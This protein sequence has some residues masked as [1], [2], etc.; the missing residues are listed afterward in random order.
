MLLPQFK[1]FADIFVL[2]FALASNE[3]EI[4]FSVGSR[5]DMSS[6]PF[7]AQLLNGLGYIALNR[8][9][10]QSQMDHFVACAVISQI[11]NNDQLLILFQ[12]GERMRNGRLTQPTEA[13]LSIDWLLQAYH[14][15]FEWTNKTLHLV[16]VSINY[17]RLF[18]MENLA[19]EIMNFDGKKPGMLSVEEMRGPK[20]QKAV[21]KA[22][23][24]FGESIE[25]T[26]YLQKKKGTADFSNELLHVEALPLSYDLVL[27]K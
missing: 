21:G 7:L 24:T 19:T 18:D 15:S 17:D 4:P 12:N 1:S 8:S 3:I 14:S 10:D 22:Y 6:M 27:A 11:L 25:L 5:E 13:D 26:S 16:P 20:M 9:R 2:L 23:L